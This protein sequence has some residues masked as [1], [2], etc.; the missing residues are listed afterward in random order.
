MNDKPTFGYKDGFRTTRE[1]R[2]CCAKEEDIVSAKIPPAYRD[3]CA[4]KVSCEIVILIV[5]RR[6]QKTVA[7]FTNL[8]SIN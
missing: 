2:T 7:A 3:Y 5:V 1:Q 4:Q 8:L 6:K